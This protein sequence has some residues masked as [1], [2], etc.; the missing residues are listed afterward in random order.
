MTEIESSSLAASFIN[1]KLPGLQHGD[2]LY[3]SVTCEN[4]AAL[5]STS[6]S[7]VIHVVIL[8]PDVTSAQLYVISP[9]LTHFPARGQHQA[10]TDVVTLGWRGIQ[11]ETGIDRYEVYI[12]LP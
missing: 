9:S 1:I 12:L 3:V 5:Q 11:E 8:P 4:N 10:I 2:S 6:C 7:D